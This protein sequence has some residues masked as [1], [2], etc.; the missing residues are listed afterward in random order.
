MEKSD[1]DNQNTEGD[2]PTEADEKDSQKQEEEIPEIS[3]DEGVE[4]PNKDDQQN[5]EKQEEDSANVST[6]QA[7]EIEHKD[8]DDNMEEEMDSSIKKEEEEMDSSIKKEE[9]EMDSSIK[10]DDRKQD[11]FDGK[12]LNQALEEQRVAEKEAFQRLIEENVRLESQVRNV[13]NELFDLE[14]KR[15]L[16]VSELQD[17]KETNEELKKN[18]NSLEDQLQMMQKQS[19]IETKSEVPEKD[20]NSP[21]IPD[22]EHDGK[23]AENADGEHHGKLPD[24]AKIKYLQV[25]IKRMTKDGETKDET[26]QQLQDSLKKTNSVLL[27][28]KDLVDEEKFQK[29]MDEQVSDKELNMSTKPTGNRVQESQVQQSKLCIIL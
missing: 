20:G 8:T 23:S 19:E 25:R 24:D 6:N 11:Q 9:E 13:R 12:S 22:N 10:K 7:E 26:I 15:D 1:S 28:L 3:K 16:L 4:N 27:Q 29:I 18:L 17:E 5:A 14:T 2:R 21:E